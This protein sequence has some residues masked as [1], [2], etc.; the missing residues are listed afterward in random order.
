MPPLDLTADEVLTTTRAVRKRLDLTRPVERKLIEECLE[1]ATQA[2]TGR[3]RQRWDFVFVTDPAKRAALADLYRLGLARP[4]Q[5]VVRDGVNRGDLARGHRIMDSAQ[6]LFEHLHEV[7][8]L[9]VPCIRVQGRHEIDS[10]VGQANTWGSIL[11]AVWQFMLA[12]RS[13]GLGT[14]WTT[15]HL[16]YEREA[17]ELLGV[18]YETVLQTAL[19]PVAHTIGTDF[20]PGPRVDADEIAHWDSW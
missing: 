7:P 19:I 13:R 20:R 17:A 4:R 9:L 2:P 8:V 3:N 14:A 1:L 11:P 15:P 12:A 18:P 5:Q 6:H 16:H 10:H